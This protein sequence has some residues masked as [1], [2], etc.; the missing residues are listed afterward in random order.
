M[1]LA[2]HFV[3]S[4]LVLIFWIIAGRAEWRIP[5][6]VE[7]RIR[8][9]IRPQAQAV[10][11]SVLLLNFEAREFEYDDLEK[12]I[13]IVRKSRKPSSQNI[14]MNVRLNYQEEMTEDRERIKNR[15]ERRF[16][17]LII[18]YTHE[19]EEEEYAVLC[20]D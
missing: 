2:G 16:P 4:G 11:E 18:H 12:E 17:G 15:L 13:Y 10:T 8:C 6:S 5:L 9:L 7:K 3:L 1:N 20:S 14:V 19:A